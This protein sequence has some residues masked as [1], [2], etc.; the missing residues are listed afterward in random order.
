MGGIE[1]SETVTLILY[2]KTQLPISVYTFKQSKL[3]TAI[4][5]YYIR[6]ILVVQLSRSENAGP[7][8]HNKSF[9]MRALKEEDQKPNPVVQRVKVIMSAG[10]VVVHAHR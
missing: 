8:W 4:D 9:I 6:C 1:V 3:A 5:K 7:G 2:K 10:L